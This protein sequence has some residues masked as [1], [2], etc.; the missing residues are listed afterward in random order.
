[1][2]S[3]RRPS[4]SLQLLLSDDLAAGSGTQGRS[5]EVAVPPSV[6]PGNYFVLVQ[7]DG[8]DLLEEESEGNN[9]VAVPLT[10]EAGSLAEPAGGPGTVTG[11][12]ASNRDMRAT[13][14]LS[15]PAW[16]AQPYIRSSTASARSSPARRR[17]G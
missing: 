8:L 15:S 16:F 2:R 6:A 14:R 5:C 10:V 7:S 4:R 12:P 3:D 17:R 1:M 13:L 9:V 11:S